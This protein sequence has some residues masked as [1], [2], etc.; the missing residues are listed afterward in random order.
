MYKVV[1]CSVKSDAGADTKKA[2]SVD[3]SLINQ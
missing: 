3:V 1:S 2:A